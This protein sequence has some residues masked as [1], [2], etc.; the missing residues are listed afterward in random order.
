MS[1]KASRGGG[2]GRIRII[3]GDWRGRRLPV[4]EVPGLRPT[5]DRGRETL[6]N[7]LMPRLPGAVVL[8]L[9]AGSGALGLEAASRGAAS[10]TLVEQDTVA[11]NHLRAVITELDAGDRV[12]VLQTDALEYLAQL[13]PASLDVVFV[14]PPYAA[15]LARPALDCLLRG[16]LL[17]PG[18]RVYWES[19][20]AQAEPSLQAPWQLLREKMV[21][22]ARMRLLTLA[23]SG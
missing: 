5:G 14:D 6:F 21:G 2:R 3:G 12:R 16:D 8:D 15:G 18:A 10:A 1:R 22:Q 23:S 7:W 19:D 17:K 9:F 20:S 13:A 4:P 11:A